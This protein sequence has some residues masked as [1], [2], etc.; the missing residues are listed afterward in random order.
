VRSRTLLHRLAWLSLSI[1]LSITPSLLA[2][3]QSDAVPAPLGRLVDIGSRKLHLNCQGSGSPAVIVENGNGSFSIDMALVQPEVA[4]FTRVCTY[5][6]AGM[7]WS[8]DGPVKGTVEQTTDDLH[9]L[10][11]KAGI[12]PPYV[13]VGAS[14]GGIYVRSFQRR[15][16]AEVVGLVL[17]DPTSDGGLMYMVGGKDTPIYEMTAADMATAF[18]PLIEKPRHYDLPQEVE[19]PFDRLPPALRPLRLWAARKFFASMDM[20]QDLI[21]TES[22]REEFTALHRQRLA[23][24]HPLGTLPLIVLGRLQ[25]DME[26]RQKDL[27]DLTALSKVG[28]LIIVPDSGHEIHLYQP[29]VVVTSI[30]EVVTMARKGK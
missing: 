4:K 3:A 6:R 30:H 27:N 12:R 2:Q 13:L 5:D 19:E 7:A 15:F 17:D 29:G 24:P 11:L 21:T 20:R 22:W 18:K 23:E 26:K 28:K 9:L 1:T 25:S 16:P 14:I 8:E 10:L